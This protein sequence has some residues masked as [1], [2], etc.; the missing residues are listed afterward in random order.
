MNLPI[1]ADASAQNE[2]IKEVRVKILLYGSLA[3]ALGRHLYIEAPEDCSIA[4]LRDYLGR[5]YPNAARSINRSR[6]VIDSV[7]V[8]E[9]HRVVATD[10]VEL[11]P[12]VSGG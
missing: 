2:R 7:A 12:P 9:D 8:A 4:E 3:D 1:D 5:A 11:L 6:A 10:H